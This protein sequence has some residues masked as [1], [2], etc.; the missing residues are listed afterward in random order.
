MPWCLT[1]TAR[2]APK[3]ETKLFVAAYSAVKGEAMAAAALEVNTMQPRSFFCTCQHVL[4]VS[5]QP[6]WHSRS[7]ALQFCAASAAY[8][9]T[10]WP[11]YS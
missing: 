7:H 2:L 5:Q 10:M 1:S 4:V 11:I 8:H 6:S 3:E 9:G